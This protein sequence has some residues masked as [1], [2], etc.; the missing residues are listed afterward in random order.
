RATPSTEAL[1]V[2]AIAISG[3]TTAPIAPAVATVATPPPRSG[4][5]EGDGG[6]ARPGR[7]EVARGRAAER[8]RPLAAAQDRGT[9]DE[10]REAADPDCDTTDHRPEGEQAQ[11]RDQHR[12]APRAMRDAAR[13]TQRRA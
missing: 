7:I 12:R 1:P 9:D 2:A 10:Q 11:A 3:P 5:G 8:G 13:T 6:G 4:G